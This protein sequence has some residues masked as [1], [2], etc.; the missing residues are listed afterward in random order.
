MLTDMEPGECRWVHR[1]D[2]HVYCR[3]TWPRRP[4]DRRYAVACPDAG[5]DAEAWMDEEQTILVIDEILAGAVPAGGGSRASRPRP[6][7][8]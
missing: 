5:L 1:H 7:K 4:E 6:A 2:I 8:P 3:H